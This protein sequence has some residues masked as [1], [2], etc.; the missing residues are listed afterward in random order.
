MSV[1]YGDFLNEAKDFLSTSPSSEIRLRSSIS[2]G[3]YALYHS[4]L[5]LADRV[6]VPPVSSQTGPSHKNLR[7]FYIDN[8][9]P[10]KKLQNKMKRVGYSLKVLHET[11]CKADYELDQNISQMAADDF[12]QRCEIAIVLVADLEESAAA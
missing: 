10:D 1:V 3:Y 6:H 11:R 2:R 4:A 8:L 7:A 12:V 9:Y 5:K